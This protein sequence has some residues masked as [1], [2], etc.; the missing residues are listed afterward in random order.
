M[1]VSH[2]QGFFV[3][4]FKK[5]P[6]YNLETWRQEISRKAFNHIDFVSLLNSRLLCYV[7]IPVDVGGGDD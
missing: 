7:L 4:S 2:Y 1:Q 3:Q 5:Q 6:F